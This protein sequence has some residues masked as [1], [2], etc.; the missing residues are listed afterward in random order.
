[1]LTL[2]LVLAHPSHACAG[3][4][5]GEALKAES[6][7]QEAIF[8]PADGAVTVSYLVHYDGDASDFGWVVPV[9]GAFQSLT[10]GSEDDFLR[11]TELTQPNVVEHYDED[12]GGGCGC[13]DMA[14]KG[15]DNS[16]GDTADTAG[17]I[18]VVAEGFAGPYEYTAIDA[19]STDALLAWLSDNGWSV[20]PSEP[21]LDAYVADGSWQFVAIKL[22]PD[23]AETP[24][25]GRNLPPVD[26]SY[27]GDKIVFPSRMA[28]YSEPTEIRT[29]IWVE[30]EGR[31]QLTDGWTENEMEN[32]TGA[33]GDDSLTIYQEE[34][35]AL[36]GDTAAYA[37]I[38]SGDTYDDAGN[39]SWVTRFDTLAKPSV[40]NADAVFGP[41]DDDIYNSVT[42]SLYETPPSSSAAWLLLPLL[43]LGWGL[44]RKS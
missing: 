11:L 22:T 33:I 43:G 29:I 10:E 25:E 39:V 7:V 41:A 19:D 6:D 20:G 15:G 27:S 12:G 40:H 24:P 30:A 4:F 16:L 36:S 17:G 32:L 8:R 18:T 35:R 37:Q 38:W 42:I 44:R 34:L 9:P 3:M 13:T 26:I 21:S 28:R 2:L 14:L 1:M 31:Y 5:H 23:T